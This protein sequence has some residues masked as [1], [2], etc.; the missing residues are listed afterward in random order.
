MELIIRRISV[1]ADECF[2]NNKHFDRQSAL[3]TI[4][5]NTSNV[6]RKT[7]SMIAHG[8]CNNENVVNISNCNNEYIVGCL[9]GLRS[10]DEIL[11]P[12]KG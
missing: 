3:A 8:F 9:I 7:N 5:L 11:P 10:P 4:A 6:P 12:P 1:G 2:E